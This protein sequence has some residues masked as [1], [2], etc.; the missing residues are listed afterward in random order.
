MPLRRNAVGRSSLNVP[1]NDQSR[2]GLANQVHYNVQPLRQDFNH[3]R[4][5]TA[6]EKG[7]ADLRGIAMADFIKHHRK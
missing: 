5:S 2:P 3:R 7:N 6:G 4:Y 1:L